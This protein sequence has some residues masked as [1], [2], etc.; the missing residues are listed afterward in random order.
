M[1]NYLHNKDDHSL[2]TSKVGD[3]GIKGISRDF[4]KIKWINEKGFI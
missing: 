3:I 1:I 4:S 2:L